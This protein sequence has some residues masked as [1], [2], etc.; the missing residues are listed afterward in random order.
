MLFAVPVARFASKSILRLVLLTTTLCSRGSA[1][2]VSA[3]RADAKFHSSS[4]LGCDAGAGDA[5]EAKFDEARAANGSDAGAAGG[6]N[7]DDW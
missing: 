7:A 6:L 5:D 2:A 3:G 1:V 4:S